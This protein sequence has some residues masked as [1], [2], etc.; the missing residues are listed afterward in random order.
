V[1]RLDNV[2]PRDTEKLSDF[3]DWLCTQCQNEKQLP[4]IDGSKSVFQSEVR[5]PGKAFTGPVKF[6]GARFNQGIDFSH[7]RFNDVAHFRKAVFADVA[8]FTGCSF[9]R[10]AGFEGAAFDIGDFRSAW[11]QHGRRFDDTTHATGLYPGWP[12]LGPSLPLVIAAA[13]A[14]ALLG[15][16]FGSLTDRGELVLV[17][18]SA[19]AALATVLHLLGRRMGWRSPAWP[20][21]TS[22]VS[23]M[24]VVLAASALVAA[25][26][27]LV[28]DNWLQP[29]SDNGS[30]SSIPTGNEPGTTGTSNQVGLDECEVVGAEEATCIV[31]DWNGDT[32]IAIRQ[33]PADSPYVSTS[34]S[35]GG[36]GD[37][38]TILIIG[39]AGAGAVPGS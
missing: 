23:T 4:G 2:P 13:L 19:A 35:T 24:T 30:S 27:G 39:E 28:A 6:D 1:L 8:D 9:T 20:W 26:A 10:S 7:C 16:R 33:A 22:W 18:S 11:F 29:K 17:L 25:S 21:G 32:M 15:L 12:D 31:L 14:L 38:V 5:L 3:M 36:T 34:R 37:E